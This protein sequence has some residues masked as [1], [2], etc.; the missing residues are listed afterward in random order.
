MTNATFILIECA[1][2][3]LEVLK[4]SYLQE[5]ME[6]R[7]LQREDTENYREKKL[8]VTKELVQALKK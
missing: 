2:S 3:V 8:A 1:M 7:R 6:I 4:A 5:T